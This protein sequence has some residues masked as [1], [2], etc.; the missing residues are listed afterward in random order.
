[1]KFKIIALKSRVL[2]VDSGG[3]LNIDGRAYKRIALVLILI[4]LIITQ[5]GCSSEPDPVSDTNYYL[6]TVCEITIYDMED[7][8]EENAQEAIDAAFDRCRVLDKTLSKTV[9]T[10]EISQ[11]NNANGEWVEVS[12]DTFTL[13]KAGIYYS[14]LSGGEF[15]I[16]IGTVADLWDFYS[17]DPSIPDSD[18][19]AEALLH[20]D[21][22]VIEIEENEDGSGKVR[23]TD[24]S[25]QID[26]GGIAKGYVG[27]EMAEVLKEY[28][29]TSAVISLGGNIVTVGGK[30]DSTGFT[31]GIEEPYTDSS[32]VIG[33]VEVTDKT[34]VTSGV[35]ERQFEVD[36]VIYH[37]I[38]ST[39]DGYP[40]DTDLDAVTLIADTGMSMDIDALSTICLIKGSDEAKALIESMDGI[41]AIFCYS[42]GDIETTS[43]VELD[44]A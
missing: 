31:I 32:E 11:I 28:G 35:Y 13:I 7:M 9:S 25:A 17:D 5:T 24:L 21:Y 14:E 27:D 6:D 20:V 8:S 38:L 4:L 42:N 29:V 43:G 2:K 12:E 22:T 10:S 1:M 40:V 30:S 3:I 44:A 23:L 26:L 19:L 37:H 15:D 18:D 33:S 39:T 16:T 41:E 34:V 36:G